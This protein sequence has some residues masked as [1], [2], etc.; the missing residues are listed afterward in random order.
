[1]DDDGGS[2]RDSGDRC[3]GMCGLMEYSSGLGLIEASSGEIYLL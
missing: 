1:M 2:S 3:S